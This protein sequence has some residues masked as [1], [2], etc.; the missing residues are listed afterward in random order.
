MVYKAMKW[1]IDKCEGVRGE[2]ADVPGGTSTA[3][4]RTYQVV[5]VI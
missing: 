1:W 5:T 4:A 3:L 2:W